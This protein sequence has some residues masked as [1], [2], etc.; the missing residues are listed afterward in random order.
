MGVPLVLILSFIGFSIVNHPLWGFIDRFF[1][2]KPSIFHLLIDFPF[3]EPPSNPL[4][5]SLP[6]AGSAE[7]DQ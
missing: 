1:H 6:Q 3:G 7:R 4:N 5:N 2:Y